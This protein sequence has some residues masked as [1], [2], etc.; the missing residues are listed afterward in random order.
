MVTEA[1]S[2]MGA[3]SSASTVK[4]KASPALNSRPVMAL[5]AFR[6]VSMVRP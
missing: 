5:L 6:V 4:V 2:G 1:F 3:P